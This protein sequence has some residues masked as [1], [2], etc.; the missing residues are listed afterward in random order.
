MKAIIRILTRLVATTTVVLCMACGAL[1]Q[2]VPNCTV[3]V[4]NR[5]VPL[6]ADGTWALRNIPANFGP[7]RARISCVVDGLT[8]SGESKSFLISP[9][10][11]TNVS[12]FNYG[13]QTPIPTSVTPSAPSQ[14]LTAAGATVQ[15]SAIARYSDGAT[16]DVTAGASG[17]QY[18]ISNSSIATISSDGLVRAVTSGTVLIQATQE[19]ASGLISISIVL[20][21]ADTDGDGI[22]DDVELSLGLDPANP[23]DASEDLDRDGLTNLQEYQRGTDLRNPDSDGDGFGDPG[24]AGNTCL[25]DNCPAVANPGQTDTDRDGAGD[26]CDNCPSV[27]NPAQGDSDRDGL[28]DACDPCTDSDHDGLGDPGYP[29]TACGIDNCPT[30][31]SPV[32]TEA[33]PRMEPRDALPGVR[34][35]A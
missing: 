32:V 22:P 12:S 23:V 27:T 9:N 20:K 31:A 5:N 6:S 15:L 17:T 21:N 29:N 11:A 28:G 34:R 8:I 13:P 30:V 14:Q 1:A 7:L 33:P 19:G 2:L 10:Q 16:R 4:L 24:F 3:S 35:V 26:A 25:L 18:T